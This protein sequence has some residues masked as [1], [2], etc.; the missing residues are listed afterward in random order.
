M[1]SRCWRAQFKTI[2]TERSTDEKSHSWAAANRTFSSGGGGWHRIRHA[3]PSD[4]P[5]SSITNDCALPSPFS[6]NA[7]HN[8]PFHPAT[9]IQR[10]TWLLRHCEPPEPGLP[11]GRTG[12]YTFNRY[13]QACY[14]PDARPM[15]QRSC[16]CSEEIDGLLEAA[17]TRADHQF[18]HGTAALLCELL[19]RQ[20]YCTPSRIRHLTAPSPLTDLRVASV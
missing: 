1:H 9:G 19:H 11:Y 12:Q 18:H 5:H 14:L 7:G 17:D 4:P 16:L 10:A 3:I 13:T 15:G 20:V 2:R 8:F 6:R